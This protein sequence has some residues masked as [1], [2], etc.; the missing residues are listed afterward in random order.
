MLIGLQPGQSKRWYL[1]QLRRPQR[2]PHMVTLWSV[3]PGPKS[4]SV[5]Y[6]RES[7]T[8]KTGR[9]SLHVA[10]CQMGVPHSAL[11]K[12]SI[13]SLCFP[14]FHLI[15]WRGGKMVFQTNH[16]IQAAIFQFLESLWSWNMSLHLNGSQPTDS[17]RGE[18][19]HHIVTKFS[20]L[21]SVLIIR[22]ALTEHLLYA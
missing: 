8:Q 15:T 17:F 7:E 13:T 19:I 10:G 18:I 11:L 5:Q 12:N 22:Q 9:I 3:P 21:G 4:H 6:V 20:D 16:S 1:A 2:C 14:H